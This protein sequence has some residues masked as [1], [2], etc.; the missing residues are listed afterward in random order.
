MPGAVTVFVRFPPLAFVWFLGGGADAVRPVLRMNREL[1]ALR[2][3][4]P[5]LLHSRAA[6]GRRA[7]AGE[8]P[9][10]RDSSRPGT[11]QP[12]L[13]AVMSAPER[14]GRPPP[15]PGAPAALPAVR[16]LPGPRRPPPP[17]SR[18]LRAE[19]TAVPAG[20]PVRPRDRTQMCN[21]PEL[22]SPAPLPPPFPVCTFTGHR[23]FTY[24]AAFVEG[25]I[26]R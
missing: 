17:A 11:R 23:A 20:S 19:A 12:L 25:T 2:S 9:A 18:E 21:H 7:P 13:L 14:L 8:A 10:P 16:S 26:G 24:W 4:E 3:K 6:C 22:L 5:P 15:R 1:D